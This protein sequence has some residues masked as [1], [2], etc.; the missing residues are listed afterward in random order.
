MPGGFPT[1]SDRGEGCVVMPGRLF[2]LGAGFSAPAG[3]PLAAGLLP[4]VLREVQDE[5][6]WSHL[7]ESLNE[8]STYLED[9]TGAPAD[10]VDI[11][12]FAT[13]LDHQHHFGMLGSDTW[14]EEG[15]RDQFLLRWG[16]GRVLHGLTPSHER[17]PEVYLE[18]ATGLRPRDTVVTFNYDLVLERA[19]DAV[20]TS[21]RRFPLRL[22]R[23]GSA[24]SV[25]DT[26]HDDE[27]VVI[28]KMHGSLDWISR[29]P[30]ERHLRYMHNVQGESGV[31]FAKRHDLMFGTPRVS[32]THQLV[33][34][35]V[36]PEDALAQVEV[37]EDL[38]AYYGKRLVAYHHPPLV[39]AP[40]QAKQL[41][42]GA[43]R[44]FWRGLGLWAWG[45][46]GFS[47]VGYSLP[48]ADPY[49]KQVLY[50]VARGY[51]RGL[52]D[53]NY[54][55]GPMA[56]VCVVNLTVNMREE[57]ELREKYR[58]LAQA[59]GLPLGWIEWCGSQPHDASA[60]RLI[61]CWASLLMA[62]LPRFRPRLP[63]AT[64]F[65]WPGTQV[66]LNRF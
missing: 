51:T 24:L 43:L 49:A 57:T 33:E 25:V 10:P 7:Q 50:A 41:Y 18:F 19:L 56:K 4:L 65:R 8:Y 12:D 1:T 58:F 59:H 46:G 34:G 47:I 27:E 14:S 39:L 32:N 28:L 20:G 21:Y 42:G 31:D 52:I 48:A 38:D 60:Q 30:Y 35:P 15:N 40:S 6:G 16:I 37:I 23:V 11:E 13:Y 45:W 54:R 64:H 61:T 36:D 26:S 44:D 9:T 5:R 55:L 29:A 2:F 53:A 62:A 63:T 3:L 17:L 66:L 22:E